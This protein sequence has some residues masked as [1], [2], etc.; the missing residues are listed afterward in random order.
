VSSTKLMELGAVQVKLSLAKSDLI[1]TSTST[2]SDP[3]RLLSYIITI[4][5]RDHS[6]FMVRG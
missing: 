6:P 1:M 5:T 4:A 2:A 3:V